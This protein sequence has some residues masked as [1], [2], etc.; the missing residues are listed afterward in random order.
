MIVPMKLAFDRLSMV[1]VMEYWFM[2]SSMIIL[3]VLPLIQLYK[4]DFILGFSN[5][6]DALSAASWL[7]L[8]L[9]LDVI[10]LKTLPLATKC[11]IM[12]FI[13]TE[14][15]PNLTLKHQFRSRNKKH[16]ILKV[17][18]V[19]LLALLDLFSLASAA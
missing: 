7:S 10:I 16:F 18:S 1:Q 8:Y 3:T 4:K 13:L 9:F 15:N 19:L 14:L 5:N 6:N 17:L 12:G 2:L 11:A